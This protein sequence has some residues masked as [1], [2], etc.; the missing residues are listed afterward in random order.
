MSIKIDDIVRVASPAVHLM[1]VN[2]QIG[3]VARIYYDYDLAIVEFP[4]DT[5]AKIPLDGLVKVE[6]ER[7]KPT[8]I[9]RAQFREGAKRLLDPSV[10]KIED[11]PVDMDHIMMSMTAAIVFG[12]LERILL[13]DDSENA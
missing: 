12:K 10:Y 2:G 8:E 3:K 1:D 9:T 11:E 13:G 7:Q 6:P 4:D 5:V